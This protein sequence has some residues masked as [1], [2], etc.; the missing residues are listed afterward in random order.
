MTKNQGSKF[1]LVI[2][3]VALYT[4]LFGFTNQSVGKNQ[5]LTFSGIIFSTAVPLDRTKALSALQKISGYSWS[6]LAIDRKITK[7]NF[8]LPELD[9]LAVTPRQNFIRTPEAWEI[10]HALEATF[11][12]E[13]FDYLEPSFENLAGIKS[14]PENKPTLLRSASNNINNKNQ[15]TEGLYEWHLQ[16]LCIREAWD[17]SVKNSCASQGSGIKIAHPDSGFVIHPEFGKGE[18]IIPVFDYIEGDTNPEVAPDLKNA[19]NLGGLHGLSTGCLIVSKPEDNQTMAHVTGVAPEAELYAYRVTTPGDIL[20]APVLVNFNMNKLASAILDAIDK[21]CHVLSISLGGLR[22]QAVQNAL[23]KATAAGMIIICAAGNKVMTVVYP[24][25]DHN[26]I[27]IAASNFNREAWEFSSRG[28]KVD[29]CA[30]GE[31]IYT[32]QLNEKTLQSEVVRLNGTSFATAITAGLA[33]LWLAHHGRENLIKKYGAHNLNELF[34]YMAS[35]S[36][37]T[38]P[39]SLKLQRSGEFGSGIINALALLQMP[40]PD[41]ENLAELKVVADLANWQKK[42]QLLNFEANS[43]IIASLKNSFV[44]RDD[45]INITIG[46]LKAAQ[47]YFGLSLS[48]A[49]SLLKEIEFNFELDSF[50]PFSLAN[51]KNAYKKLAQLK[52][53]SQIKIAMKNDHKLRSNFTQIGRAILNSSISIKLQTT[54]SKSLKLLALA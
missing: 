25:L 53:S 22:N 45:A 41:Y 18:K 30:P 31:A 36:T 7:T 49:K 51:K 8:L 54:L 52:T 9:Y 1:F 15:T 37:T 6:L 24:A 5:Q 34:R 20:P 11:P 44:T 48:S 29:F 16:Q 42:Q 17:F 38:D 2:F 10:A 14:K 33:A 13:T 4:N 19:W 35:R 40:L 39:G 21:G 46:F 27:A 28:R 32:A 23:Q 50:L 12:P 3:S 43:G 26:A 47:V